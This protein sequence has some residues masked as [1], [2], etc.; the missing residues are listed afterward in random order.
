M[1]DAMRCARPSLAVAGSLLIAML[2]A[3]PASAA[4]K[5]RIE[6]ITPACAAPGAAV[7]I[8]GHRFG[9]KNIRVAVG[10]APAAVQ[11]ATG[12]SATFLVPA[13]APPG[14]TTVTLTHKSGRQTGSIA[15][16]VGCGSMPAQ[17]VL[18]AGG[19]SALAIDAL[20]D[21]PPRGADPGDIESGVILS[22]LDVRLAPD[23]TVDQVNA[24]LRH[25]GGGI[26]TMHPGSLGITIAIPR[27]PSVASLAALARAL[28]GMPGIRRAWVAR[29]PHPTVLPFAPTAG[30]LTAS[31]NVLPTRFP[32]AWNA[33]KLVDGCLPVPVL[34]ADHFGPSP[35][36]GFTSELP[37]F[38]AVEGTTSSPTH[39]YDV[40]GTMAALFNAAPPTGANPFTE[41]LDL[42]PVQVGDLSQSEAMQALADAFPPGKFIVNLSLAIGDAGCQDIAPP[43]SSPVPAPCTPDNVLTSLTG[44][45]DRAYLALTWKE[46]T[47]TRWVDFLAVVAAGNEANDEGATIYPGLAAAAF[48]LW[49]QINRLGDPLFSFVRDASLWDPAPPASADFPSLAATP[50]EA[51]ALAQDIE[52]RG[53][54]LIDPADNV[55]VA[56]STTGLPP[57][58]IEPRRL[59][60]LLTESVFSNADPDVMAVGERVLVVC[61][62][63]VCTVT[64]GTSFAAPQ[65]AG[66]A[67][68]LW[69][70]SPELR[71]LPAAVMAEAIAANVFLDSGLPLIDA[72]A[73]ALSLDAADLPDAAGAPVRRALLDVNDDGAFDQQDLALFVARFFDPQTGQEVQP[74]EHDFSRYDL[75]G[76]G[77]TGGPRRDRFDLDRV[78]SVRFGPTLYSMVNQ[79]IAGRF[80]TYDETELTDLDILCYHAYSALYTSAVQGDQRGTLLAGK[81]ADVT[82]SVQPGAAT[83]APGGSQQFGASVL[84]IEDL[85]VMWTA[86]GGTIS[87]TGRFTAGSTAGTFAVRA[88]S[89]ADP[90]ASGEA[91]VTVA[92]PSPVLAGH[93]T[94][95]LV[96]TGAVSS[97][98]T[99]ISVDVALGG[100]VS[101]TGT[102]VATE[103]VAFE[104]G[105]L[106]R[107]NESEI[108]DAT[109]GAATPPTVMLILEAR[110]T[111]TVTNTCPGSGEPVVEAVV[112]NLTLFGTQ[113]VEN[114]VVVAIDFNESSSHPLSGTFVQTGTLTPQP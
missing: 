54:H 26:V 46:Q 9:A 78:G 112:H 13:T 80:V 35:P 101:A 100:A 51:L 58:P 70:L 114:G 87:E 53:L 36:G 45:L 41:C 76:D 75:N 60:S 3:S 105:T 39:G 95:T 102:Y 22:R 96:R 83:V 50:E 66:L 48:S 49:P 33:R 34:V 108:F 38:P 74:T 21:L 93:V 5:N 62:A 91:T 10:G 94:S 98:F 28:S 67:S 69:L 68:Y 4:R 111:R 89:V 11:Q 65:V 81:C 88:T 82:V 23:A 40:T 103:T 72:Y 71:S 99:E 19:A 6:S 109:L 2:M 43:L 20:V 107:H 73:A 84:G 31:R 86:T 61:P 12:H 106:T 30:N 32:A 16:A 90:T 97:Q 44:A 57:F 110:G 8:T 59:R 42:R 27:Q 63:G 7:T 14:A 85:A 113:I 24:A 92:V 56:G 29:T 52:A 64:Q 25:V 55:L 37:G 18:L 79:S 1:E 15:F 17:G 104:C 77:F 47:H